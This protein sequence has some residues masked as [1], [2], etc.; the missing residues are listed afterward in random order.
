MLFA[1]AAGTPAGGAGEQPK[2]PTAQEI[3]SQSK[4]GSI[5][6]RFPGEM[7][8]KTMEEIE[9]LAKAGDRAARTA[10]KLLTDSRFD[11]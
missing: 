3:I 4:K 7:L 2:S 9:R 6:R 5:N 11:K 8:G 1:D 10:K